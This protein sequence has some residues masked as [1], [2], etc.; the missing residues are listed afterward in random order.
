MYHQCKSVLTTK[1]HVF[2]LCN[3]T[4]TNQTTM[5]SSTTSTTTSRPATTTELTTPVATTHVQE[6][7]ESDLTSTTTLRPMLRGSTTKASKEY[8]EAPDELGIQNRSSLGTFRE[9]KVNYIY[10]S[11]NETKDYARPQE[12]TAV[13]VAF[14][15]LMVMVVGIAYKQF[16]TRPMKRRRSIT[17]VNPEP[18][19]KNR[20]SWS[21]QPYQVKN[22]LRSKRRKI[23]KEHRKS[24][25]AVRHQL[26][27]PQPLHKVPVLDLRDVKT[28]SQIPPLNA[29]RR[30]VP[31]PPSADQAKMRI[32]EIGVSK[33]RRQ[34][35]RLHVVHSKHEEDPINTP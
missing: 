9:T 18:E 12:L 24:M 7:R 23:P 27:N 22:P 21:Q 32:N 11:S 6:K 35:K 8:N 1:K 30:Q 16:K 10:M 20:N 31:P 29:P 25:E 34:V 17:P 3:R 26:K 2:L 14:A 13:W 15:M 28:Q 19:K 5:Y 33:L 4:A